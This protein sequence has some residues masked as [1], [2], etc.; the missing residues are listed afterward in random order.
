[1]TTTYAPL[2]SVQ[3]SASYANKTAVLR[4]VAF[5]IYPGEVLGLVGQSGSGKSTIA[6]AL[7]KLLAFKAGRAE[8]R[9]DFC[10]RDLLRLSEAEMR[11]VR[12]R[13]MSLVL[14]SPLSSLNPALRIGTQ[15]EEAWRAHSD[16]SAGECRAAVVRALASVSLPHDDGFLRR[17]ASQISVGQAQRVLIAMAILH[18]PELLIA[19]EAT[20]SLDVITQ[21]EILNL[22]GRFNRERGMSIL[23]ISHDL[24][25]VASICHR[26]AI[27]KDGEI[28]EC[29]FTDRIFNHPAHPYTQRLVAALPAVPAVMKNAAPRDSA[30]ALRAH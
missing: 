16:S 22:F 17:R 21:S 13:Q 27:L 15:L 1:M 6:L 28:V 2:L 23:Y 14:Q 12:G 7:M 11:K 24:L 9:I 26:I 18:S 19:D 5:D 4:D 30:L 8:G 25:S 29:D 10:G 3:I 20:S